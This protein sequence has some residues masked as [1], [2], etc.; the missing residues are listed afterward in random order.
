MV[1]PNH[2]VADAYDSGAARKTE[3]AEQS[4]ENEQKVAR[5]LTPQC[6]EQ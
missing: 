3:K 5:T 6:C 4:N 1:K 2:R